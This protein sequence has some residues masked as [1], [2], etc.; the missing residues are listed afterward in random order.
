MALEHQ[1]DTELTKFF[2]MNASGAGSGLRYVDMPERYTFNK[3]EKKWNPRT[4]KRKCDVV[5]RVDNIHP[6]AGDRFYLRMLLHSDHC[7]G[8]TGFDDLKKIEG[9]E[10]LCES[11]KEACQKLGMLQDDS[12]WEMVLEEAASTRS[13]ANQVGLFVTI[14]L[15]NNPAD[16]R[17]L[18]E[19]FW[20]Q[21][22]DQI[23]MKARER[24]GVELCNQPCSDDDTEVSRARKMADQALLKTLVLLELKRQFYANDKGLA[25]VNLQEP[26]EEEEAAVAH[27]TGGVSV[28]LRDE[29][30]F[31]VPEAAM[32]A[33]EAEAR[34]TDEQAAIYNT[35][36]EAVRAGKSRQVFIQA[37]GGCGKT[38]LINAVLDKVRSMEAG[39]CVAL[40][41]ATTGKAAMHLSKGR[42]FHS[43]FKAPL[44][45]G[46]DCSLRIPLG[47]EL[48]KLVW[49]A[50]F[51]VVDEATMLNNVLLQAL[52][53]CFRDIMGTQV[54]FRGQRW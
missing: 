16:P 22:T 35:L 29:L 9:Q 27:I 37:A 7:I 4:E 30:D 15:F 47:S 36:V 45:L 49:M 5:G 17:A 20:L 26:T 40:A 51:I 52:D 41:T 13:C 32:R 8:A 53:A 18:F 1:R 11:Y 39:G 28:I 25:D 46:E 43:R 31:S 10:G 42:T 19:Q 50:K 38:M 33:S 6:S 14:A 44:N 21:W 34:F 48:A 3:K 2:E 24:N 12:E 54:P 23:V